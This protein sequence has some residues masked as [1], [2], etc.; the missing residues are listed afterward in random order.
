[1]RLARRVLGDTG[2]AAAALR[3]DAVGRGVLGGGAAPPPARPAPASVGGGAG[4]LEALEREL[5]L[6]DLALDLLRARAEAL[7]L[8]PRDGDLQR[9]RP[10]PRR[11]DWRPS[12]P[13]DLRLL[14]ENDRLQRGR[15][16]RQGVERGSPCP[17][18]TTSTPHG[19]QLS[20]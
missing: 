16:V 7:L 20:H 17:D 15:I 4:G 13:G 18:S 14:G 3:R 11:R 6:L 8:Q 9:L 12:M 5:Q 1:M 2:L 10:R 19:T